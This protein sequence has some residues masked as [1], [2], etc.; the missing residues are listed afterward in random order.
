MGGLELP[1]WLIIHET[2]KETFCEG[3][4]KY[5]VLYCVHYLMN[6]FHPGKMKQMLVLF[7]FYRYKP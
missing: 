2:K 6:A 3:V 1:S 7:P 5:H 4:F